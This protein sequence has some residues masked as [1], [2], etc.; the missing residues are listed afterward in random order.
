MRIDFAQQKIQISVPSMQAFVWVADRMLTLHMG[1]APILRLRQYLH[2]TKSAPGGVQGRAALRAGA[3]G[4]LC[5]HR[6][7]LDSGSFPP[8]TQAVKP[9][10]HTVF[11]GFPTFS[12]R[13]ISRRQLLPTGAKLPR[14]SAPPLAAFF[15]GISVRDKKGRPPAGVG[16]HLPLSQHFT[17]TQ[18]P[19][20]S[21]KNQRFLPALLEGEPRGWL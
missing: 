10:I 9:E 11:L 18:C 20:L 15:A 17:R 12:R 21:V 8:G 1:S 3:K 7:R 14:S 2:E 16:E 4:N 6:L 5:P 19:Y 13:K